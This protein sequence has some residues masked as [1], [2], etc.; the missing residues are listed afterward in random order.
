MR[1]AARSLV[2]LAALIAS[3]AAYAESP[4]LRLPLGQAGRTVALS[5]CDGK[6]CLRL[7]NEGADKKPCS[8]PDAKSDGKDGLDLASLFGGG[9]GGDKSFDV[10]MLAKMAEAGSKLFGNQLPVKAAPAKESNCDQAAATKPAAP[11][12]A[13]QAKAP[14]PPPPQV[15]NVAPKAPP[16]TK[17]TPVRIAKPAPTTH[18]ASPSTRGEEVAELKPKVTCKRYVPQ[19]G[20]V[21]QVPC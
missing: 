16:V 6:V 3:S 19:I 18:A 15:A 17:P 2:C 11:A 4:A 12:P 20:E 7:E 21:A 10:G 14:A 5:S 9:K 13:N 1:N 8:S